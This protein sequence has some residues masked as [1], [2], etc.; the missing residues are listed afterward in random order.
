MKEKKVEMKKTEKE[1]L[2]VKSA[3][4]AEWGTNDQ[5]LRK[6]RCFSEPEDSKR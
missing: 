5:H 6:I 2:K 1:P 3:E 4:P